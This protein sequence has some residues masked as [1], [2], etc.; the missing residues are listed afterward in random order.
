MM[1]VA[2]RASLVVVLLL[3]S[4]CTA[5]AECVWVLWAKVSSPKDADTLTVMSASARCRAVSVR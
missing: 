5:S 3:A 1:Q 4:V 2:R